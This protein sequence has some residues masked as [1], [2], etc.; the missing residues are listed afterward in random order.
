MIYVIRG[1]KWICIRDVR[2]VS[3]YFVSFN[4]ENKLLFYIQRYFCLSQYIFIKNISEKK[5]AYLKTWLCTALV[6]LRP[7][8]KEWAA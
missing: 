4:T 6:C 5:S 1:D 2:P 8:G 7:L 3:F